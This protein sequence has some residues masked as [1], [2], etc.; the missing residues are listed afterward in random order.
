MH[1]RITRSATWRTLAALSVGLAGCTGSIMGGSEG[2]PPGSPETPG[3]PGMGPSG[4]P[5]PAAPA[6]VMAG[7]APLRRL[8]ADQYRNTVQ[9]LL[10][11]GD[12]VTEGS[13]PADDSIGGERFVSNVLRPVQGSDLDRYANLAEAIARKATTD[14]PAL[15]GCYA[16][17]AEAIARKATTDLP[18]LLGCN[19]ADASC[20]NGF[21][22]RFGQRAYRRPLTPAEVERSKALVAAGGDAANGVRLL[23]QAMLQSASFLY[24]VEPAASAPP[25]KVVAVDGWAMASRLSYFL[26]NSMPDDDL[27]AAAEQGR[28]GKAEEVAAQATRLMGTQRF[29]DMVAGFHTQWLETGELKAAEKDTKL[30]TAW[31]EP[32]RAAL[33]E[34]PRRFVEH[35]MKE[36]DGKLATLLTAPYSVLTGPLYDLY[37]VPRP[38]GAAANAWQK[39][40]LDPKQRAGLLTQAGIMASLAN[41][42]RTSFIRR[43][44]LIRS[45]VLCTH[46]PDPPPGVDASE[47][48]IPASADARERATA[49]RDKPECAAC[50]ALFDPLGFAFEPYDAIGRYRTTENGKAIN[51]KTEISST[52]ALDGPVD[53]AVDMIQKLAGAAEVQ[54]CVAT[55]WLRFA[56]GR[57][58]TPDDAPSLDEA[59][60]GLQAGSG[61][62]ADLLS[63]LAQSDSFRYQKVKP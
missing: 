7:A 56:L 1:V 31:N 26:L 37:G 5:A 51:S 61:K 8:N 38:A 6:G 4:P 24:M 36:G 22:E 34:E 3:R 27:F 52:V 62:L 18:A 23:V 50:H 44:K 20:L 59:V 58:D 21:I 29:R 30:F 12:L 45:G 43:G 15:L 2:R 48:E 39:V 25:G 35:V 60:K 10:G 42:D 47:M 28:L 17:L 19:A 54:R 40:D 63:A 14:L 32:L 46:V 53:D 11:L 33:I 57:D 13:L 55:Q 49:H 16:N 9:D 41:E